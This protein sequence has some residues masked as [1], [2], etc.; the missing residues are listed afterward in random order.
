VIPHTVLVLVVTLLAAGCAPAPGPAS[1]SARGTAAIDRDLL[2]VTVP[3]LHKF[4]ADKKYTVTQ[5]VQWHLDRIDRYN[6][7][8]G[9]IETV[10]RASALAEAKRQDDFPER[11]AGNRPPPLWGV[12]IVIKA[13]TSIKG[14]VTTAGWDGFTRAGHELIAPEDA[15]IVT[16]FKAAGAIIVGIANMPDLANSDTNR[17]SSLRPHRQCVRRAL[18]AGWLVW[19]NRHCGGGEHGGAGQ[20]HRHGQFDSHARSHERARRC[21]SRRAD[22]S[23]SPASRRST[24]CS[25]TPVRLRAMPRTR[26]LRSR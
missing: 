6:G 18:L 17:S 10:L 3:Q 5:V 20:R 26:R 13:N 12:P 2:D 25:T 14:E 4:F 22:S 24:G 7:V 1:S 16:R 23:A 11:G 9:A 19:R 8:Y 21:V 15:T